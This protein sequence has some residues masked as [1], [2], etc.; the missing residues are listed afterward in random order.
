M[1]KTLFKTMLVTAIAL[2]ASSYASAQV[3][4]TIRPKAP[5]VVQTTRPSPAHIWIDEEWRE[6]GHGY[7]YVGG[8]WEAAPHPGARW[9]PGHW[10]HEH[11]GEYWVR[12]H[13]S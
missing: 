11:R 2:G 12:G 6:D 9:I 1:K 3:Y 8:H 10:V 13:W 4:V 7:K 5:V